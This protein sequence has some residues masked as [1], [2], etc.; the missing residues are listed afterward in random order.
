RAVAVNVLRPNMLPLIESDMALLRDLAGWVER[1]VPDG[2]RLKPREVVG[3]FDKYLHDELDLTREA[4]NG[5]QL[6]RNFAG[7]N[8]LL[9]PEM[10]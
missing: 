3:E 10:F 5:S 2:R 1:F 8:L 9:V 7:M 6:R 4:A